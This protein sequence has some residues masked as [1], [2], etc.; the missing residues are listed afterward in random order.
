MRWVHCAMH[1][2]VDVEQLEGYER[3]QH[4]AYALGRLDRPGLEGAAGLLCVLY[5]AAVLERQHEPVQ[6]V[7]S[8][9]G[10]EPGEAHCMLAGSASKHPQH[11]SLALQSAELPFIIVVEF[12]V[13]LHEGEHKALYLT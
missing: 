8:A 1:D 11:H 9:E 6:P 10:P 2:A 4:E 12:L 13:V 7:R 3:V 5:V